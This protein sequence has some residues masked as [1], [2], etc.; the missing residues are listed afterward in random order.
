M[1]H[2]DLPT[3]RSRAPTKHA[4]LVAR[5]DRVVRLLF[6]VE[7]GVSSGATELL[8]LVQRGHLEESA[9]GGLIDAFT[10]VPGQTLCAS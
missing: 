10:A 7:T 4:Q 5:K 1:A 2:S 9:V 3:A 6:A 8:L